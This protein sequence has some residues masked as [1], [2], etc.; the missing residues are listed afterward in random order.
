MPEQYTLQE[1]TRMI[2]Q[3]LQ[4]L[5]IRSKQPSELY[6]PILYTLGTGGK[7]IRSA[8]S[9]L[10]CNL[11]C[12]DPARAIMPATAIEVFHNYSLVHDDIMDKALLRRNKPTVHVKWSENAAILS[13]DAMF[14]LACKLIMQSPPEV[15]R[16]VMEIFFRTTLEVCEGQQL[17]MNFEARPWVSIPEYMDMIRQKTAVLLA[18]GLEIGA[19]CGGADEGQAQVLYRLGINLG[20]AFQIQDDLLDVYGDPETFG[21]AIG[22]D[23]LCNKKT[24]LMLTAFDKAGADGLYITDAMAKYYL[25]PQDK[26][27]TITRIYDELDVRTDTEAE[28]RKY[29]GMAMAALNELNV[30]EDRKHVLLQAAEHMMHR[31][32]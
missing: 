7:R 6:A 5:D 21:K 29:Y 14:I 26:I 1:C 9:L 16:Q 23:I 4:S 30:P 10:A 17:D 32:H 27:D 19:I 20:I 8:Y 3:Q 2:E 11:F 28:I 22:G 12:N 25:H 31:D 24:F 18:A 13:G 15:A